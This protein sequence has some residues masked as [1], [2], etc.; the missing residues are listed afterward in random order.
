MATELNKKSE[1][2]QVATLLT[3]IGEDAREVYSTFRWN[4]G[5]ETKIKPVLDKFAKYCQPRKNVPFERYRFNQRMHEAGETYEHYRTALRKLSEGCDFDAITPD[6]I[7]RDRLIFGIRDTKVRG[8]LLRESGL[9]LA[10][11][12]EICRAAESMLA[13]M[14]IVKDTSET[15]V[16]S[17]NK[18]ES[19]SL[20][21]PNT[22]NHYRR[23][24]QGQGKLCERCGYQH[25]A[26][27]ES[28]PA[29]GKDC[30]KCGAK[31][32]FASRCK[33]E[34]KGTEETDTY[35]EETSVTTPTPW[36]TSMVVVPKK[37]GKHRICLDPKDLNNA[38]QRENYPLPT[39]EEI[40]TRLHGA[41][42][43]TLLD[44]RNGFWHVKIDEESTYLTTF[45]TPFGR[46]RWKR[47]PFGISSAPEV[48]QR[49]MHE[50]AEGLTGTEVVA[51]DF[52][53]VGFG[54]SYEEATQDHD[55]NL[56]AF[57]SRCE[58]RNIHL[59]PD[60][61][62]LR[63]SEVLFIGHIAIDKGLK[64]DPA[65]VPA[66]VDMP[67]P[68]DKLGVQR[69]LGLAKYLAKFLPQMSDITKPLRDLTQNDV[70]FVWEDAQQAAFG[71]LKDAVTVTP[72][73]QYY[74]LNEEI[75][76]V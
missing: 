21:K 59:N 60:K 19:E 62:K 31:N 9:T 68:T 73:L 50:F 26:N 48:F 42:V 24:A 13:Q 56:L 6:E 54:E 67:P 71:K 33:Q 58:E 57:L 37:N 76:L 1:A 14:K 64:V 53:V 52:L 39:I 18:V 28:C 16:N 5:D 47:M 2:V 70:Q 29:R 75:T 49:K 65:K 22:K 8:R 41:K 27:P 25:A 12:D 36:I 55:K 35:L 51:D 38:I 10:K 20:K 30:R 4:E 46:Y 43:F 44:V 11:T 40:A 74:N 72:V 45:H 32:H 17:V 61:L 34:V 15:D 66:I 23:H 69:L 63:Q 7:L 3:V